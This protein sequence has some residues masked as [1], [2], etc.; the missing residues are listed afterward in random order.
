MQDTA[1]TKT[2]LEAIGVLLAIGTLLTTAI[3][4]FVATI[5]QP[6]EA[7]VVQVSSQAVN[8]QG[9]FN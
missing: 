8:L 7:A 4:T 6:P 2:G 3:A 1:R 9:V 5:E